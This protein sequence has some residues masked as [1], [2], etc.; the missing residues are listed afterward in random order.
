M[1]HVPC[2]PGAL[3]SGIHGDGQVRQVAC[4]LHAPIRQASF[5]QAHAGQFFCNGLLATPPCPLLPNGCPAR[6]PSTAVQQSFSDNRCCSRRAACVHGDCG[7]AALQA[8]LQAATQ[9]APVLRCVC[10]RRCYRVT[11]RCNG[12]Q[13]HPVMASSGVPYAPV[14]HVL[15]V[16]CFALRAWPGVRDQGCY[17]LHALRA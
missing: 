17:R 15:R 5:F 11:M 13:V 1:I 14:V 8:V 6:C 3:C 2:L 4:R 10:N 7:S 16:A 9:A 12:P